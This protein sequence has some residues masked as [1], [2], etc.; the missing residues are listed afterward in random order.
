M[1][2][3]NLYN[4]LEKMVQYAEANNYQG[5]VDVNPEFSR[6]LYSEFKDLEDWSIN[7]RV[8]MYDLCA[9]SAVYAVTQEI[10]RKEH[11]Q[12]MKERFSKIL[13]PK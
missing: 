4:I 6:L 8:L 7:E 10:V 13:K 1:S 9:N 5:V 3:I 12:K 11:L 2:E